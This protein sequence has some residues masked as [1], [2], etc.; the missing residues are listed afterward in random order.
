MNPDVGIM[1]VNDAMPLA[2]TQRS[3]DHLSPD[4]NGT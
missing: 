3:T 1:P 4:S 2:A